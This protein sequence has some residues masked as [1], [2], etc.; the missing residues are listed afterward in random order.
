MVITV[1]FRGF[2][3]A[4]R[5]A[6]INRLFDFEGVLGCGVGVGFR[7]ALVCARRAGGVR[8]RSKNVAS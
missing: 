7:G 6:G 4:Y 5:T 2:G 8:C 3:T 1:D